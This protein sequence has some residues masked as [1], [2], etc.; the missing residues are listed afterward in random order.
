MDFFFYGVIGI[1]FFLLPLFF[2][3]EG[4]FRLENQTG[5][6]FLKVLG[7]RVL[8]IRI[9]LSEEGFFLSLN[10]KKGKKLPRKKNKKSEIEFSPFDAIRIRS[11]DLSIYAG[12]SPEKV[13]M[14]LGGIKSGTETFLSY[15]SA[16]K[17][18][19]DWRVRVFPCYTDE[20]GTVNFSIRLFTTVAFLLSAFTH[21]GKGEKY[22][23]RS[24]RK[25]D[26]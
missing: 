2:S 4:T 8:R 10:G 22:A 3:A 12:G 9:L 18:V 14:I 24:N 21:T 5:V 26:G 6:L 7:I 17:R 16:T 19:D 11:L 13:S 25:S 15:L 1:L 20:R 23:K